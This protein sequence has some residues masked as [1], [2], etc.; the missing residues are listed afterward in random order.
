[1]KGILMNTTVLGG[2][3]YSYNDVTRGVVACPFPADRFYGGRVTRFGRTADGLFLCMEQNQEDVIDIFVDLDSVK[4]V[5]RTLR[6][7]AETVKR[8]A[9]A[10]APAD[11]REELEARLNIPDE[12]TRKE[13]L[14]YIRT[15]ATDIIG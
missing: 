15:Y 14:E 7:I 4:A 3:K 13:L 1:M 12:A 6:D 2:K 9:I 11:S 8:K 5:A 10:S